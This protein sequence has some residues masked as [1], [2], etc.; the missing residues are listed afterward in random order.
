[1]AGV[2][3]AQAFP[4]ASALKYGDLISRAGPPY[5]TRYRPTGRV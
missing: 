4:F 1:M 5:S 3:G 2:D